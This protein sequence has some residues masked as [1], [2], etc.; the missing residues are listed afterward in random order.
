MFVTLEGVDGAGK[1]TQARLL[2]EALG[3]ETLLLREP[4][5]T[6]GRRAPARAA[7]GRHARADPAR[8]AAALLRGAGRARRARDPARARGRAA[9]SSATASSTPPSPTRAARAA[10][11]PIWSLR[12][13]AGGDRRLHARP[14]RAACAPI[15]A[16]RRRA[17]GGRGATRRPPTA[18]SGEGAVFQER[19]RRAAFERI[20]AAEPDRVVVVDARGQRRGSARAGDRGAAGCER[21]GPGPAGRARPTGGAAGSP[22]GARGGAARRPV[23]RVRVRRPAGSRQVGRGRAALVAELLAARFRPTPTTPAAG[24]SP[25]PRRIPTWS[26]CDR[27]ATSTWSTTSRR[28]CHRR[29]LLPA[30]RGPEARVRHRGRRG[31]GRGE[32]ERAA[33]DARG[34]ARLRPPDPDHLGA[35]RPARRRCAAAASR[36]PSPPLSPEAL[37][38]P[39]RAESPGAS[40]EQIAALAGARRRRPRPRA[41]ARPADRASVCATIAEGCARAAVAGE[42]DDRPWTALLA[43]AAERGKQEAAAVGE[44]AGERAD[45]LGKGRDADRDPPR[46]ADA[47]KRADRRARTDAIDL[48]LRARR[49]L[50]HRP[51]RGRR[52]RPGARPERRSREGARRRR[53]ARRAGCGA[54]R[55]PSS[56]WSPAGGCGST[57]TRSSRWMRSSTGPL[58][59]LVTGDGC[60]KTVG[61]GRTR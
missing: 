39:P 47:A 17:G 31:D 1:S 15:P 30:L 56:R 54:A 58:D 29:R 53:S 23:A 28:G 45:E 33:E 3:P 48:G 50:V 46:G 2:A 34:A 57:S 21:D 11:T 9:T 37:E 51:G 20:A 5:G 42:L 35:R 8:R 18:S 44:A 19:D 43:L 7:Q 24:R 27:P 52:G 60:S 12:L 32:P 4:G 38:R 55:A 41:A 6:G 61:E 13:N 25:I 16:A 49:D 59:C 10:S 26:G 14:N 40:P 22:G 36:S